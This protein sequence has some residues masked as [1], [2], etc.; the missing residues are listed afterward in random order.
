MLNRL[1]GVQLIVYLGIFNPAVRVASGD[2]NLSGHSVEGSKLISTYELV[3]ES[4]YR[5]KIQTNTLLSDAHCGVTMVR[6]V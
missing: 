2:I 4:M 5:F 6:M 1:V 3:H